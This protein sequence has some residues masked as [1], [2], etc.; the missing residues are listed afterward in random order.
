MPQ[1][2]DKNERFIHQTAMRESMILKLLN[3]IVADT[4]VCEI[5]GWNPMNYIFRIK[6]EMD[7][8]VLIYNKKKKKTL[9]KRQLYLFK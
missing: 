6:S 7:H 2:L 5:E 8:F 4:A 1:Q 9:D 3:D